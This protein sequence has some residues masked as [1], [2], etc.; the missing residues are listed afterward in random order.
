[1]MLS[2]DPSSTCTGFA[3]WVDGKLQAFGRL[4][5]SKAGLAPMAR[6]SEMGAELVKL[7]GECLPDVVV[8]EVNFSRFGTARKAGGACTLAVYGYAVGYLLAR[9]QQEMFDTKGD[10]DGLVIPVE[11]NAWTAGRKISDE[12]VRK[13]LAAALAKTYDPAHDPG[14]NAADAILLGRWWWDQ[15]RSRK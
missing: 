6:V 14:A 13:R 1:M 2:L 3:E 15:Q 5:P 9:A 11:A 4:K 8:I 7:I 10:F 12:D